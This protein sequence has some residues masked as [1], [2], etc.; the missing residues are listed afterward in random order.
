MTMFSR[1]LAVTALAISSAAQAADVHVLS[2]WSRVTPP[3]VTVGVGYV[4][5]HNAGK[6]ALRLTGASSARAAS[7]EMH[8][9][10]VDAKGLSTMRPL[11]DVTVAAGSAVTF[12]P[13]G[14]HL[15]LLGLKAPLVEGERVPL[16]LLFEGEPPVQVELEVRPLVDAG[17]APVQHEHRH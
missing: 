12:E 3:G 8:E 6:K 2:A 10:R 16:S 9:T 13:G 5:V 15:M 7:V 14:R 17:H 1:I 4:T 11:H